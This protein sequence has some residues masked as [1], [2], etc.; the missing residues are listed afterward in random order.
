[1]TLKLLLNEHTYSLST[2]FV[3][4]T[5]TWCPSFLWLYITQSKLFLYKFYYL[6]ST[7]FS[8]SHILST[9]I[10][11]SIQCDLVHTFHSQL[12]K[13]LI[14]FSL[15]RCTPDNHIVPVLWRLPFNG[16]FILQPVHC[17]I[18][19]VMNVTT[20]IYGPSPSFNDY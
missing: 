17:V 1:M 11:K 16:T 8:V 15:A 7:Q 3:H 20:S 13:K 9:H 5:L 19:H 6:G 2:L 12:P 14:P 10:P 4:H 18:L